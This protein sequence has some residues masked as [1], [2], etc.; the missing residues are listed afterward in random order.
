MLSSKKGIL[1]ISR[2]LSF[3]KVLNKKELPGYIK[4]YV[5][6]D[7]NVLVAYKT[8]RDHAIFTDNKVVIFDTLKKIGRKEIYTLPY[9]NII[10]VSVTFDIID[11]ELV[12]YLECGYP[13][14]LRFVDLEAE[15][16]IRLRLLYTYLSRKISDEKIPKELFI[17]LIKDDVRFITNPKA[18]E[19]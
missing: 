11:A 12:L 1:E 15:D 14:K 3:S 4:H 8:S 10:S 17:R 13:I 6:E 2:D 7:E 19:D 16:K 9:K 5:L 18:F